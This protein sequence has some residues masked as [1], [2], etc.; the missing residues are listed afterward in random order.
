MDHDKL[1]THASL[2]SGIGGFDL[3]AECAGFTN[4]F[5]CD[6]DPFCRQALDYHFPN[7]DSYD[8]I[9]TTDFSKYRNR[10]TVLSGGFPCQ[11][12]SLAGKR[13]GATDDRYLW[14]QMLRAIREIRPAWIIGENVIGIASMV[15]PAT[16]V[17]VES[18]ADQTTES[19]SYIEVEQSEFV[20]E[21]ICRDL[22]Q[23]G[24]SVQPF[25][26]PACSV[27]A[28]HKRDR[29]WIVARVNDLEPTADPTGFGCHNGS[30]NR[31]GGFVPNNI[32]GDASQDEPQRSG[33]QCGVGSAGQAVGSTA[34]TNGDRCHQRRRDCNG[35]PQD[36][37][38]RH[39][40]QPDAER[41]CPERP[42]ADTRSLGQ[43]RRLNPN[44]P[45]EAVQ[46]CVAGLCPRSSTTERQL[47]DWSLFPTQPPIYAG[48]DGLPRHLA[49]QPLSH[50]K[51]RIASVKASG[52][53][54]VPQ[55]AYQILRA[56]KEI[57][58]S[59]SE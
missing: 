4:I 41:P 49:G 22:E 18:P 54:I 7:S 5:H 50:S 32:N 8:D 14:P 21:T 58:L 24:Y 48:D 30:G 10:I 3:A 57:E 46:L 38:Q 15:Q 1:L 52:N 23:E 29:V 28:P 47:T 53:A 11:P 6:Y 45:T 42:P 44:G 25:I 17:R 27:G 59:I 19:D 9:K 12:F 2:F 37:P 26:I 55:V 36:T 20:I 34:N 31:Q 39:G 56:I 35:Q 33:R 13:K 51:W 43:E 16:E 40:V